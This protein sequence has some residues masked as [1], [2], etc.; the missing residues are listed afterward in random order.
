MY[1]NSKLILSDWYVNI[2]IIVTAMIQILFLLILAGSGL[3][4][5]AKT[6][7]ITISSIA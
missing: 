3:I 1:T 5:S 7:I 2:I 6:G 4:K